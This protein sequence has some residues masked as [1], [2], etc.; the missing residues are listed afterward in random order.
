MNSSVA[1]NHSLRVGA[2]WY[3]TLPKHW[4]RHSA[5][6]EAEEIHTAADNF[7]LNPQETIQCP[8]FNSET[9]TSLER[10]DELTARDQHQPC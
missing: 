7:S 4:D 1:F 3:N 2:R 6:L 8:F 5:S 10:A 9:T